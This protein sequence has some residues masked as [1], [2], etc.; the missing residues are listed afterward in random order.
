M[1]YETIAK[2]LAMLE[3]R[4]KYLKSC[5]SE[6]AIEGNSVGQT[7]YLEEAEELEKIFNAFFG[8]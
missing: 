7:A 4:I 6:C 2:G 8:N 1:N 5:A 3:N